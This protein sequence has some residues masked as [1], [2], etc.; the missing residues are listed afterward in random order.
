MS[1]KSQKSSKVGSTKIRICTLKVTKAT[2][3]YENSDAL[4]M[5]T[6][7]VQ[8]FADFLVY[9]EHVKGIDYL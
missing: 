2:T 1:V 6:M 7:Y 3:V 4:F 8:Y 9:K 5:Y